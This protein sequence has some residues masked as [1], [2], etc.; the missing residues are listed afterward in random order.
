MHDPIAGYYW[1]W[2]WIWRTS[3]S[4]PCNTE[5]VK[6][7][8]NQ[9]ERSIETSIIIM[10]RIK[11]LFL[12]PSHLTMQHTKRLPWN[13]HFIHHWF[14]IVTKLNWTGKFFFFFFTLLQV[15]GGILQQPGLWSLS[16]DEMMVMPDP[17]N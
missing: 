15:S 6:M 16:Q 14:T 12:F 7:M 10:W 5:Q 13:L 3:M 1:K 11:L 17:E 4:Y 9:G 8:Q 2:I